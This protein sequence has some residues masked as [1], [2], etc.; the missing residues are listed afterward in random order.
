MCARFYAIGERIDRPG[1]RPLRRRHDVVSI[2]FELASQGFA[3]IGLPSEV[4]DDEVSL[5]DGQG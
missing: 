2:L 4:G 3:P 1:Q 5:S